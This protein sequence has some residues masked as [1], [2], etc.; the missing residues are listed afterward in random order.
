MNKVKTTALAALLAVF[1]IPAT[2]LA[3]A[4]PTPVCPLVPKEAVKKQFPWSAA[5]DPMPVE[6]EAIGTNGSSCNYPTVQVQ[7]LPWSSHT[8]ETLKKSGN[9][10]TAAGVGDAAWLRNNRGEY[11]E[12]FV[13]VGGRLLT[14][15]ASIDGDYNEAK[16]KLVALAKEYVAKLR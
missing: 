9:V 6:E 11:A 14:L 13:K 5:L 8:V 16:P 7:L 12:I 15:Q 10:E 4:Q 1:A 3:Q 2:V